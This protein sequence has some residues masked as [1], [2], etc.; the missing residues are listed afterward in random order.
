MITKIGYSRRLSDG[1]YGSEE[2]NA[3]MQIFEGENPQT[4]LNVLKDFVLGNL[5]QKTA[6]TLKEEVEPE[7]KPEINEPKIA[8][9]PIKEEIKETP[10]K[11]VAKKKAAKK[12]AKK[13]VK[14]STNVK[15]SREIK[16]HKTMF[17]SAASELGMRTDTS[18]ES[19][20]AL[21]HTSLNMEGKDMF[22]QGNP[23]L[24]NEFLCEMKQVYETKL[25]EL[26]NV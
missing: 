22:E 1:N 9:T 12:A 18:K 3:E 6:E 23:E 4:Q 15:Y 13:A 26:T 20:L 11:K 8:E 7:V 10:K 21:K 14:K 25:E 2:V 24:L 19:K 16:P 17:L 5:G